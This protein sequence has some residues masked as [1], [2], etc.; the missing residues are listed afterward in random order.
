MDQRDHAHQAGSPCHDHIILWFRLHGATVRWV[1]ASAGVDLGLSQVHKLLCWSKSAAIRA[2]L[3]VAAKSR[4]CPFFGSVMATLW[5]LPSGVDG[6]KQ[7]WRNACATNENIG[8]HHLY[9]TQRRR[10][11]LVKKAALR[12]F[13]TGKDF[14]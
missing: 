2:Y 1:Y 3:P 14:L 7:H 12:L 11:K 4:R 9:Q 5:E 13:G 8:S 6:E 10:A